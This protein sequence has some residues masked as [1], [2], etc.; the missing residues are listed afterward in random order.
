MG[1]PRDPKKKNQLEMN[2]GSYSSSP[3]RAPFGRS[4]PPCKKPWDVP[5]ISAGSGGVRAC[6]SEIG[7]V[8]WGVGPIGG[9]LCGAEPGIWG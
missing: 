9:E 4:I 2:G 5:C 3:G 7:C 1:G 8:R 6:G